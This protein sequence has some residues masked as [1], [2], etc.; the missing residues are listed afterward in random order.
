MNR[1]EGKLL[2]DWSLHCRIIF[3]IYHYHHH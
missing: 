2:D 3:I 1:I